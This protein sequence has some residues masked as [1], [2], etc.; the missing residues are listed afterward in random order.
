MAGGRVIVRDGSLV[1]DRPRGRFLPTGPF[2]LLP[3][4]PA[5]HAYRIA[6]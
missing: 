5:G 3:A 4:K 1:D 6:S 2:D